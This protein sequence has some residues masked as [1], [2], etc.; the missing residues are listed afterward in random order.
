MPTNQLTTEIKTKIA[1]QKTAVPTKPSERIIALDALRGFAILGILVMN[2]QSFS[3]VVAAYQNPLAYGN[4]TGLN[5]W[6]WMFSHIFFDL[7]FMA[8]FSMMFGAGIILITTS[9][10][11]KGVSPAKLHYKRNFWLL[12]F[13]LAHAYLFWSGDILTTYAICGFIVYVFRKLSPKWLTLIGVIL[14]AIPSAALLLGQMS[15]D[16]I[17]VEQLNEM[18]LSWQP[19]A[20]MVADEIAVFQGGWLE[21]M[22]LRIPH[23]LKMQTYALIL[24]SGWRVCGLMLIGM[25]LF[26]WGVL[27]A[28][29]SLRFYTIMMLVGFLLGFPLVVVGVK[30]NFVHDW[31]FLYGLWVGSQ[32][33]YWGSLLVS[34]GYI[35][36]VML[37]AKAG[38]I[39]GVVKWFAS[40]GR[41]ALTN[42]FL[43]TIICTT[44]FYG[45][46][47]GL[48]G[49]VE[50]T[51]QL[52]LVFA[53]W[54][55]QLIISPVWLKRYRFGPFEW[56]WRSLTYW[57]KQPM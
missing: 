49:Q 26:K 33:N 28:K 17:P 23:S 50:R 46:G 13:G 36:M 16:Y 48:F 53:V 44:I 38:W 42:Y 14:F 10:E 41:M 31:E 9:A 51:G 4:F 5:R 24:F 40:V 8:M 54:V 57:Q 55:V 29:R 43:Q 37:I 39:P 2:I 30:Q 52:L 1:E 47:L 22:A 12:L 3:M 35:G 25:A 6:V 7:K 20:E 32:F 27:T 18:S 45:H 21:Q 56:L 15:V 11:K 19:T 34:F